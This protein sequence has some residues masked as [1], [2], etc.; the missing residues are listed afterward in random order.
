MSAL[1]TEWTA[2]DRTDLIAREQSVM[3]C[4]Q[5]EGEGRY[6]DGPDESAC[7]MDCMRCG[8][9]GWIV[10]LGALREVDQIVAWLRDKPDAPNSYGYARRVIADA[11]E[12]GDHRTALEQGK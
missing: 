12:R 3:V 4:P 11:I 6:P 7:D 9:N 1:V 2:T 5:C 10:D 8:S